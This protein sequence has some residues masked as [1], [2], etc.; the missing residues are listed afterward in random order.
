MAGQGLQ[1][2][3]TKLKTKNLPVLGNVITELN[4]I[5]GSDDSDANQLA[6][7]ILRDPNLTSHVLKV[8]NTVNYNFSSDAKISTVSRAIV[9]IGI[10]GVRAICISSMA[11]D[12]LVKNKPQARVMELVAQGFHAA[13]QAKNLLKSAGGESDR[14]EEAFVAGL[15]FNLGEMAFW[16]SEDLDDS[17]QDLYSDSPKVRRAAMEKVLGCSFKAI[18]RELA[19]QWNLGETL[20]ASLYPKEDASL[21]VKA[22][23]TGE[24][25]SRASL[26]GWESPQLK[27]VL[28]EVSDYTG[29]S[30]EEA[31]KRVKQGG[32]Q[33]A[34]VALN[35]GVPEACPLIPKSMEDFI[36]EKPK[37]DDKILKGDASLQLNILRDLSSATQEGLD[38]NTIFQ[39]VLEGMHRGIGLERV[40]IAFI[41][42]HKL[43]AKYVLGEGAEH[44]RSSFLVDVGPFTDNVFTYAIENVG[45]HWINQEFIDSKKQFY[46]SD[47]TTILG[48]FPSFVHVLE[49]EG[50]RVAIFYADRWNFGGNLSEAQFESFKH[51]CQQAQLCLNL[52]SKRRGRR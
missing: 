4:K 37:L 19:K 27:K 28:K 18:T 42:G 13:T 15:L 43:A 35:Y 33:A 41:K 8:A 32:D 48:K 34:E 47:V 12:S 38:V 23:V 7:V 2:W 30:L 52:L 24:R 36:L 9:L 44:W 40:C 20:E 45:S 11:M 22:V 3:V 17:N 26:Y 46:P 10:K 6:E 25:L 31:L 39:M 1:H 5:T 50:R 49:I 16:L 51:F 21:K 14:E 29:M